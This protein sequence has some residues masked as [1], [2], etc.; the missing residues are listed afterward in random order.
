MPTTRRL[1]RC[2]KSSLLEQDMLITEQEGSHAPVQLNCDAIL[3][4]SSMN[5]RRHPRSSA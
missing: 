4:L 1:S 2:D 5:L 3:D